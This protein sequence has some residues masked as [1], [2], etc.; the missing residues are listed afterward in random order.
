MPVH[1][2]VPTRT[3]QNH[4]GHKG[5]RGQRCPLLNGLMQGPSLCCTG[6]LAPGPWPGVIVWPLGHRSER[7]AL[8]CPCSEPTGLGEFMWPAHHGQ[9]LDHT[10]RILSTVSMEGGGC[11]T[12][13]GMD[14]PRRSCCGCCLLC[15]GRAALSLPE[16]SSWQ[17]WMSGAPPSGPTVSPVRRP[18]PL[19]REPR[20]LCPAAC[21]V[22]CVFCSVLMGRCVNH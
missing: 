19:S 8:L 12:G 1:P 17:A 6:C 5:P 14:S 7:L 9:L 18:R 4:V 21:L 16:G 22:S 11:D 3:K 20:P 2:N 10:G 15:C 13:T